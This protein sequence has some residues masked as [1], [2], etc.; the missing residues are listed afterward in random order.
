MSGVELVCWKCGTGFG[1]MPL[2]LSRFAECR[3]CGAKLHVCRQCEFYDTS[4]A[5]HCREPVAEEVKDKTRA[6]FCDYFR[7]RPDA[8]R[9]AD[10][11]KAAAAAAELESLFGLAGG[12]APK[13]ASAEASRAEL[14]QLF[15]VKEKK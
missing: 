15:G 8:F 5:K 12:T 14:D 11:G 2:P 10:G 9:A 3:Q 7:A 6:N 4:V 1:D 13:P